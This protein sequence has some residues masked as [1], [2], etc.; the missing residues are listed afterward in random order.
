MLLSISSS[1]VDQF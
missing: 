1:N